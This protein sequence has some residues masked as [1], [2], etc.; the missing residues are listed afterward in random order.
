M[1]D[2]ASKD[3]CQELFELSGWDDNELFYVKSFTRKDKWK[4]SIWEIESY[5]SYSNVMT[6]QEFLESNVVPAYD[7]GYLLRKLGSEA[8]NDIALTSY[9][10]DA[11]EITWHIEVIDHDYLAGSADTPEDAVAKLCI[12][13]LK[14]DILK[15]GGTV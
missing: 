13:L 9:T 15:A 3:L 14:Q 7:L 6:K 10:S 4:N 2:T 12:T 1:T 5:E 8:P 11:G